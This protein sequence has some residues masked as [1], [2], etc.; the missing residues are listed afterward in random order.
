MTATENYWTRYLK[1]PA[2]R[3]AILRAGAAGAGIAGL[4]AVG[5]GGSSK[6]GGSKPAGQAASPAA[7]GPASNTGLT[8]G[9]FKTGGTLQLQLNSTI[10]LDPYYSSSFVTDQIASHSYSRLFRFIAGTDPSVFVSHQIV[11]DL[12]DS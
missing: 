2:S 7:S 9:N 4:T 6:S 12:V 5:C 8:P 10:A 1:I 3:R 11:G